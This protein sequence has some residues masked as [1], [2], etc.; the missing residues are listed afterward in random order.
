[1]TD[2]Y[3]R[4]LAYVYRDDGMFY[5]EIMIKDGYAREYT[6][7]SAYSFQSQFRADEKIAKKAGIGL[8]GACK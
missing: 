3:S 1:M 5:N 8:W 4:Y 7:G 2:K 6:F